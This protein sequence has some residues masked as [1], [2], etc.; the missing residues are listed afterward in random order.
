MNRRQ[1]VAGTAAI[2]VSGAL[3]AGAAL[4]AA[5]IHPAT[6]PTPR[7]AV[8]VVTQPVPYVTLTPG[9]PLPACGVIAV[10]PVTG[11]EADR[12]FC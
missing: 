2:T 4:V 3:L 10:D 11:N 9:Q 5:S 7:P 8:V 1:S 12:G 6:R